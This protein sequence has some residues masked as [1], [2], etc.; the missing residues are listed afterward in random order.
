MQLRA[1]A[2]ARWVLPASVPQPEPA[3]D[4]TDRPQNGG[5]LRDCRLAQAFAEWREPPTAV[6]WP[7]RSGYLVS[8]WPFALQTPTRRATES[9]IMPRALRC[10]VLVIPIVMA[11]S[12]HAT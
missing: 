2:I 10:S 5:R 1:M 12:S 6:H 9:A 11:I 8:S 3:G 4:R 7:R